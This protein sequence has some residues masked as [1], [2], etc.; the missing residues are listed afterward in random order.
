MITKLLNEMYRENIQI[1]EKEGKTKLIYELG[2]LN[3]EMKKRILDNKTELLKRIRENATARK[4]GL[5]VYNHGEF[6][7]YQYGKRAFLYIER[8][9]DGTVNVWRENYLPDHNDPYKVKVVAKGVSFERGLKEAEGFIR[10]LGRER[11]GK[12]AIKRR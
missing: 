6:Y 12:Y 4:A 11:N 10:W 2:A 8:Q 7:E 1:I 3:I 5:L 9:S